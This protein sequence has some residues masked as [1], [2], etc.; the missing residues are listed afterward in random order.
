MLSAE[1]HPHCFI[2]C[3]RHGIGKSKTAVN[4]IAGFFCDSKKGSPCGQCS[5]CRQIYAG[6]HPDFYALGPDDKGTIP[7]GNKDKKEEGTIR[8]LLN[9]LNGK[10]FS[11]K[12]GILIN[13]FE[14]AN[15][16]GMNA[17]LKTIEEPSSGTLIILTAA[18]ESSVL[19]TILSRSCVIRFS[20]LTVEEI[21]QIMESNDSAK[22]D[23]LFAAAASGGSAKAAFEYLDSDR[24]NNLMTLCMDINNL[25]NT[26]SAAT[27]DSLSFINGNYG[28]EL[29]DGALSIYSYFLFN[30]EKIVSNSYL[31][32]LYI[33]GHEALRSIIKMLLSVKKGSVRNLN[34]AYSLKSCLYGTAFKEICNEV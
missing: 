13:K 3:G 9:Y 10:S 7:L 14:C 27:T 5:S 11:G 22:E 30:G 23:K 31:N 6:T 33:D 29:I 8:H 4:T 19:R 25:I 26:V 15:S 16:A 2:F 24:R 34:P 17:L 21:M 12:R 32:E 1:T 18:S 20:P 28:Y